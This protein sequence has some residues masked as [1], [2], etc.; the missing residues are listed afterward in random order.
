MSKVNIGSDVLT[1]VVTF[2]QGAD[3]LLAKQASM[4]DAIFA[5]GEGVIDALVE[6]NMIDESCKSASVEQL[7]ES[8]VYAFELL[9]R[10]AEHMKEPE[11]NGVG[12]E[13]K[14]ASEK[15]ISAD[16]AFVRELM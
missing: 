15:K 16:D 1:S 13:T 5:D 6:A 12:V 4:E 8:P 10:A 2:M 7:K 3:D 14:S 11:V 9:K